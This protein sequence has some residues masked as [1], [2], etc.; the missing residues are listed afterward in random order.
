MLQTSQPPVGG[1]NQCLYKLKTS[2]VPSVLA[3]AHACS[4]FTQ[5]PRAHAGN[6]KDK[7]QPSKAESRLLVL[8][9]Q[10]NIL[11]RVKNLLG[12][13]RPII[14][15]HHSKGWRIIGPEIGNT[16]KPKILVYKWKRRETMTRYISKIVKACPAVYRINPFWIDEALQTP[17]DVVNGMFLKCATSPESVCRSGCSVSQTFFLGFNTS[18]GAPSNPGNVT[19]SPTLADS[20]GSISST[21]KIKCH[22]LV[23]SS[24]DHPWSTHVA[25]PYQK[26]PD[27]FFTIGWL[28]KIGY[29][30]GLQ[31]TV[32]SSKVNI[33]R[34]AEPQNVSLQRFTKRK[35]SAS[36]PNSK[37]SLHNTSCCLSLFKENQNPFLQG[38]NR[39][40]IYWAGKQ[41]WF[42][43]NAP[44]CSPCLKR[45][46]P[47]PVTWYHAW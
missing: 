8:N 32:I 37:L 28:L 26:V 11:S 40:L 45:K 30:L 24:I 41:I 21:W 16:S 31:R 19:L 42:P 7:T 44:Q 20:G 2:P 14:I 3:C 47:L 25:Q 23:Y 38:H 10:E 18:S 9:Y 15:L 35:I 46:E 36:D 4:T 22:S 33:S 6:I 17:A 34:D 5:M 27:N 39:H 13:Y 29:L 43:T 12:S 1:P